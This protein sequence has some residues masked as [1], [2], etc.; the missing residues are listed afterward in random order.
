M[1]N[2]GRT[3]TRVTNSTSQLLSC[4]IDNNRPIICAFDYW[5]SLRILEVGTG[6]PIRI[7]HEK[8]IF[9]RQSSQNRRRQ[10][11]LVVDRKRFLISSFVISKVY[12]DAAITDFHILQNLQSRT[13]I[14]TAATHIVNPANIH[15]IYSRKCDYWL[16]ISEYKVSRC[17]HH[18]G[19]VRL[20]TPILVSFSTAYEHR[21]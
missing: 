13:H 15:T 8:W 19:V 1:F 2:S 10:R 4:V 12:N 9:H 20:S 6:E 17:N 5:R 16:V 11:E 7:L 21:Q 3:F 14:A 18:I